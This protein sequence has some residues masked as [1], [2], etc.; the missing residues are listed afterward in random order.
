MNLTEDQLTSQI[1]KGE[2][3]VLKITMQKVNTRVKHLA[4]LQIRAE[5]I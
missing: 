1:I 3:L 4:N 5:G 2:I